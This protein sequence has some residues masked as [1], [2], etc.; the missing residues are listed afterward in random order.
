MRVSLNPE[1]VRRWAEFSGDHNPI[2]FDPVAA[3]RLSD[4]GL[5]AHGMLALLPVKEALSAATL[6]F[7]GKGWTHLQSSFRQPVPQCQDVTIAR[8]DAGARTRFSVSW[9]ASGSVC[10]D[11][12]MSKKLPPE[13]LRPQQEACLEHGEI[14][15]RRE[16]F[17]HWFP[18]IRAEWVF[19]DAVV[20][21]EF[22]QR[23]APAF[24]N[25]G[26]GQDERSGVRGLPSRAVIQT[27]QRVWFD[28]DA[29]DRLASEQTVPLTYRFATLEWVAD[30]DREVVSAACEAWLDKERVL[31]SK[32]VLLLRNI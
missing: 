27:S 18:D 24:L 30:G 32:N 6:S 4:C 21:A 29:L 11:G 22:V 10:I 31:Y 26:I 19:L 14:L 12:A 13:P 20:F 8:R 15:R 17:R 28:H 16:R 25:A 9:E 2:H 5:V 3:A 23:S 1:A 7:S